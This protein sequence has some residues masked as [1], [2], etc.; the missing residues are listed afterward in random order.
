MSLAVRVCTSIR[1]T[2]LGCSLLFIAFTS[3]SEHGELCKAFFRAGEGL[4]CI[5]PKRGVQAKL[6]GRY[7]PLHLSLSFGQSRYGLLQTGRAHS[8]KGRRWHAGAR[9][10]PFHHHRIARLPAAWPIESR[11]LSCVASGNEYSCACWRGFRRL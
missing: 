3:I 1:V 2:D 8:P 10:S 5:S 4:N 7:N 6:A 9:E 11:P